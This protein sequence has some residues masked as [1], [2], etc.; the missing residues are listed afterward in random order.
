MKTN[1]PATAGL[2]FSRNISVVV[3]QHTT[4]PF[5]TWECSATIDGE[6]LSLFFVENQE[7]ALQAGQKAIMMVRTQEIFIP[8]ES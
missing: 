8:K 4:A 2:F 7:T 5:T 6:D 3:A 1:K